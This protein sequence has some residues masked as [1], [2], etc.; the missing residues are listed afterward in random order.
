MGIRKMFNLNDIPDHP[1]VDNL[2]STGYPNGQE[3]VVMKCPKCGD[4]C[5]FYYTDINNEIVGCENCIGMY[6]AIDFVENEDI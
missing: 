4:E 2:R 5:D 3:P 1:V 6:D